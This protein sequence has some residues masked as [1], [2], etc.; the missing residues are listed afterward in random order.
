M[1]PLNANL[2]LLDTHFTIISASQH[3]LIDSWMV[4]KLVWI[5]PACIFDDLTAAKLA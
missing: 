2:K 3:D 4:I 5:L 1:V